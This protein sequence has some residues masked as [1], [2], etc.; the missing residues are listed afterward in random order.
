MPFEFGATVLSPGHSLSVVRVAKLLETSLEGL[1]SARLVH[2]KLFQRHVWGFHSD[3]ATPLC[4]PLR[5]LGVSKLVIHECL[6]IEG[7]ESVL[8]SSLEL[9]DDSLLP[10]MFFDY[11]FWG[12]RLCEL[13]PRPETVR[14]CFWLGKHSCLYPVD[15]IF[16][17]EEAIM[18]LHPGPSNAVKLKIGLT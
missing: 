10:V 2:S 6:C 4:F 14:S 3:N 15:L 7:L 13:R 16:A 18:D 5:F 9:L 8:G 11:Y 17:L 1:I 12:L